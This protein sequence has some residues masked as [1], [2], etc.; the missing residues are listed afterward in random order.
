MI[1]GVPV[2]AVLYDL[3]SRGIRRLAE[4]RGLS[5]ASSDYRGLDHVDPETGRMIMKTESRTQ[6]RKDRLTLQ[7]LQKQLRRKK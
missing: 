4:Y 2:F 7:K 1:I 6:T 5:T 3:V